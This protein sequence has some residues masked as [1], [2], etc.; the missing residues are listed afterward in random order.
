MFTLI[1]T[2]KSFMVN[3]RTFSKTV[4][5]LSLSF[6]S[7]FFL[8]FFP[9]FY[10]SDYYQTDFIYSQIA[11]EGFSVGQRQ[12]LC[13]GRAILRN[14]KILVMDEATAS[15]DFNTGKLEECGECAYRVR[16]YLILF[17]FFENH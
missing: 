10:T 17:Y 2:F 5:F 3:F 1:N 16:A 7:F 12:L 11:G 4:C 13:I 6:S 9:F 8:F 15:L 14:A